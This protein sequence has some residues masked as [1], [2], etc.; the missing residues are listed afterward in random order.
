MALHHRLWNL[1]RGDRHRQDLDD[2]LRLHLEMRERDNIAGGMSPEEARRDAKLRFGN[3]TLEK[4]RTR[5]AGVVRALDSLAQDLRYAFRSLKNSRGVAALI[6]AALALGIGAN[7]AIFSITNALILRSL[8]VKDPKNLVSVCVGNFMSW[9]YVEA[10][11]T[12][13][14]A[15]WTEFDKRQEVLSD[16]FAY[17]ET[18]MDL[19]LNGESK[20]AIGAFATAPM[21]RTLGIEP[22]AGRAFDADDEKAAA[23]SPVAMISYGLWRREF[24]MDPGVIGRTLL[25]ESKPFTIVGVMP[26]RFLGMV[27]GRAADFYLPVAA[28]PYIRGKDSAFLN[29]IRYWLQVFGRLRPDIDPQAAQ[30]R[31]AATG[32]LSMQAT[33]PSELPERERPKYVQQRFEWRPAPSGIS[34]ARTT[35][36]RPLAVLSGLAGL[37]LL[38]ACFT[39]ANLLLARATSRTRETAVRIALGAPRRRIV[40]QFMIES[41]VLSFAGAVAGLVLAFFV[42]GLLVRSYSRASDPLLLDLSLDWRVFGF[43]L[44]IAVVSAFLLGLASALRAAHVTPVESLKSGSATVPPSVL[45][46]RQALLTGQIAVTVVLV[47]GAVLFGATLRNLLTV[48]RGFESERVLLASIDLRRLNLAKDARPAFYSTLLTQMQNLP[49]VES[50]SL[51][52][53]TPISGSTWQFNVTP[54]TG[55][56]SKPLH[57]FYNGVTP[58]F[59]RTFGTRLLAGR[60]FLESDRSGGPPVAVVNAT[61]A[62]AAF[63]TT[64]AIG[65]RI[66]AIDPEPQDLEIVGIVEDVKYRNLRQTVPPTVYGAMKQQTD[67]PRSLSIA[68]RSRAAIEPVAAAIR[69]LFSA[70][71]PDISY[72]LTSF[73]AQIEDSIGRDRLLALL[74]LL[75]GGLALTVAA[76]GVYG[77]LSFLIARRRSEI[78]IRMAL[79]ATPERVRRMIYRQSLATCA[80]GVLI[81]CLAAFWSARFAAAMLYG[82]TVADPWVYVAAGAILGVVALAATV[83][84]ALRASHTEPM[85]VLRCE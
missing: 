16:Y 9:G 82:I 27:V 2:E 63:G 50:A 11:E 28:E 79:G 21:F 31:L 36:E 83:A 43:T 19:L 8:P 26:S 73:D 39:V 59:F 25:I 24:S 33:V 52:Y 10:E 69:K 71:Y 67:S 30:Q 1:L 68:L 66:R 46:A 64:N 85:R 44:T 7:T 80:A 45:R 35:L 54:E 75:F 6:V 38:L 60:G 5:D 12:F 48:H 41:F 58:D 77:V 22:A 49:T 15:L 61:F 23:V 37:L 13:T 76:I 78:G 20:A 72:R 42:S 81:G 62:K 74:C 40:R 84:P 18:Q 3:L 34:Y 56:N 17:S 55:E 65:R 47:A 53:V 57:I 29:P 32:H 70:E 51:S 4:E 14:H